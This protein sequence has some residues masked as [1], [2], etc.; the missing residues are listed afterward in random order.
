LSGL[1]LT[2]RS[3]IESALLPGLLLAIG[4]HLTGGLGQFRPIEAFDGVLRLIVD[5]SKQSGVHAVVE[6]IERGVHLHDH[7]ILIL[8]VFLELVPLFLKIV[9]C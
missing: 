4:A 1:L 6:L 3:L 9:I 8:H 7:V 2:L 5:L